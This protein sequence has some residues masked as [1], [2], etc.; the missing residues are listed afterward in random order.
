MG[1]IWEQH[2]LGEFAS[3]VMMNGKVKEREEGRN[4]DGEKKRAN[5]INIGCEYLR[6]DFSKPSLV[7]S[8]DRARSRSDWE[9]TNV[10][11]NKK[12]T[13]AI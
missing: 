11:F 3:D 1:D 6:S 13:S 10:N 8:S 2:E 7:F 4:F 12:T 5:W 9:Q